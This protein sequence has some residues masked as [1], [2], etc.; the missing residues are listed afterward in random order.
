MTDRSELEAKAALTPS[1]RHGLVTKNLA[2]ETTGFDNM[3]WADV[4]HVYADE[5]AD[6]RKGDL[7]AASNMLTAQAL[8]LD[9][10]FTEMLRRAMV[11]SREYPEAFERYMRMA[12][13]AQTQSRATLE[14]LAKLHQPREQTVKHVH[15]DNRGGQA[16]VADAVHTG[17]SKTQNADQ[18]HGSTYAGPINPALLGEDPTWHGVPVPSDKGKE[19]V[20]HPRRQSGCTEGQ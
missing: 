19:A 20:P 12:L 10:V 8:T 2:A 9:S 18:S 1:M 5:C 7:G 11:N 17:G 3:Q 16:L 14:A 6:T 13:K 4:V 15:I